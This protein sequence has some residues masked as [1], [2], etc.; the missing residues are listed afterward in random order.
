MSDKKQGKEPQDIE[1]IKKE[2]ETILDKNLKGLTN[3]EKIKKA[4]AILEKNIGDLTRDE[5]IL[6]SQLS[7]AI[8]DLPI[9]YNVGTRAGVMKIVIS[10]RELRKSMFA[11]LEAFSNW[12]KNKNNK[13]ETIDYCSNLL[14]RKCIKPEKASYEAIKRALPFSVEFPKDVNPYIF[15]QTFTASLEN[16]FLEWKGI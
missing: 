13:N 15:Y 11:A 8:Y 10:E 9:E 4:C 14:E 7:E 1:I 3:D 6:R 12:F 5:L 2:I 16:E